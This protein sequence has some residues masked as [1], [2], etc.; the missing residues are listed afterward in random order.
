RVAGAREGLGAALGP[1]ANR[2]A[3]RAPHV[4]LWEVLLVVRPLRRRRRQPDVRVPLAAAAARRDEDD[5]TG[6]KRSCTAAA[7]SH[8]MPSLTGHDT[9]VRA[10]AQTPKPCRWGH[11]PCRARDGPP[12]PRQ[13]EPRAAPRRGGDRGPGP[14][15]RR[16]GHGEAPR[17]HAPDRVPPR[18]GAPA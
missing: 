12:A 11:L 13:A 1:G 2:R 6:E 18:P 10:A 5:E 9:E 17:H 3:L 16:R 15:P 14:R 8:A 7:S 4:L